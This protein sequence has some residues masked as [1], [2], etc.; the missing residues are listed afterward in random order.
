MRLTEHC[1]RR[2]RDRGRYPP[3][4]RHGGGRLLFTRGTV[5]DKDNVVAALIRRCWSSSRDIHA[6]IALK[7]AWRRRAK[8]S[9]AHV[10]IEFMVND[11]SRV[12]EAEVLPAEDGNVTRVGGD[13][14]LRVQRAVEH[15]AYR[16]E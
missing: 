15:F 2:P 11:H 3:Y 16:W 10:R 13:S 6:A 12:I 5:D 4:E 1:Q 7:R 9:N 14:G 8:R